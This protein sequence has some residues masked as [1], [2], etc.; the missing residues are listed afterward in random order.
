LRHTGC[1]SKDAATSPAAQGAKK[2]SAGLVVGA[3]GVVFGDIGTSPLYAFSTA[4]KFIDPAHLKASVLGI[5]S[6]FFWALVQVVTVKY[7]TFVMRADNRGEGGVFALLAQ[8]R[9]YLSTK[10]QYQRRTPLILAIIN[11]G[12]AL[13]LVDGVITPAISVLSA[14]E[15]LEFVHPELKHSVV[16]IAVFKSKP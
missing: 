8:L 4:A 5:T 12:A 7:L 11:F 6:L 9:P 15:G 14:V 10:K 16:P 3:L 13:L 2:L 1:V